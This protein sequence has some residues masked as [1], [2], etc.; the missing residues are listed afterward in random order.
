MAMS[1]YRPSMQTRDVLVLL[2]AIVFGIVLG[3]WLCK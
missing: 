3:L 2:L 1:E